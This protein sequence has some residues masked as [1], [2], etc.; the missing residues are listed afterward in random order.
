MYNIFND[1]DKF[2]F[3]I[4]GNILDIINR[5]QNILKYIQKSVINVLSGI[6][7]VKAW[8]LF[9]VENQTSEEQNERDNRNDRYYRMLVQG[10]QET[11][12]ELCAFGD[13][14]FS[15]QYAYKQANCCYYQII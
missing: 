2:H 12:D 13:T 1:F 6:K 5:I 14:P 11:N 9:A 10:L 3:H 15:F 4:F 7:K 8:E